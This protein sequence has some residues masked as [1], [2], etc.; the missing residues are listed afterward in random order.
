MGWLKDLWDIGKDFYYWFKDGCPQKEYSFVYKSFI[1]K[2][3]VYP[4]GHGIVINSIEIKVIRKLE[5]IERYF[6]IRGGNGCKEAKLPPLS[7]MQ[8]LD[9]EKRFSRA[10]FWFKSDIPCSLDPKEDLED[11]KEFLFKW[12]PAVERGRKIRLSYAFSAPCM[13]PIENGLFQPSK[14]VIEEPIAVANFAVKSPIEYFEY[15]IAF[16]GVK[17]RKTPIMKIFKDDSNHFSKVDPKVYFDPFYERYR[18]SLKKPK[19]GYKISI[20]WKWESSQ[21]RYL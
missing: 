2:L 9:P 13:F 3:A 17:L 19:L 15:E 14:A 12:Q 11:R 18:F 7:E 8:M 16:R 21:G 4:N 10:G 5:C 6:D 1:K 20:Q